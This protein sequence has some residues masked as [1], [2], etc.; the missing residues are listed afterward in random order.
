MAERFPLI[1]NS[2]ANQIQE[3]ASGD[4]LNLTGNNVHNAG[5]ITATTFKG[6]LTG[7]L[8]GNVTGNLTGTATELATNATGANL[9][10]SGNLG[11][12]GTLTYEDV[13]RVDAVGLSTFREGLQVGPLAGIAATVY[14]DGS[15]RSTGVVT[16]TTYY[17]DGSNLSGIDATAL[18]S[19]GAVKVQAN[20]HG[21]VTTGVMT[22]TS[23]K[24]DGSALTGIGGTSNII[25]DFITVQGNTGVVTAAQFVPTLVCPQNRNLV[26]NG[27]M[28]VWQRESGIVNSETSGY[29]GVDRYY[30]QMAGT[31]R[32]NVY[33]DSSRPSGYVKSMKVDVSTANASPGASHHVVL[34]HRIEG[35][36]LQMLQAGLSSAVPMTLSFWVKSPKT[37]THIAELYRQT[38]SP[39][40]SISA[41]YTVSSA[42]TWEYKTITFPGDTSGS[43]IPNS[44][45]FDFYIGIWLM[46]GSNFT[47]GS[48]STSWANVSNST[49]A[50]GQVNVFDN[51]SNDF[52]L[53]GLQLEVG[54]VATP[55]EHQTYAETL[56]VCQRYY[57]RYGYPKSFTIDNGGWVDATCWAMMLPYDSDDNSGGFPFAT[58]M[59]ATPSLTGTDSQGGGDYIRIHGP[60]NDFNG[61]NY[62]QV[63]NSCTTHAGFHIDTPGGLS[64]TQ[65][66]GFFFNST[67]GWFAFSAEL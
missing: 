35:Q 4:S 52:Y 46:A 42:N 1:A 55:F 54:N 61:G 37:G 60:A 67:N 41:A 51:T 47:S 26:Q 31:Q 56:R 5:I 25:A 58:E 8:T 12:A 22:A 17:G 6:P 11:V 21:A 53:T 18:K 49:R 40:R 24:G 65:Q 27:G 34:Q 50:Q 59:R 23:F 13:T 57:Q 36:N 64:T 14:K 43:V 63:N 9:T 3:I 2:S 16:A 28:T 44:N 15:I 62:F 32:W 45:A 19:G 33:Q 10:L 48:L 7:N 38:A 20:S 30:W 39:N 66:A 29:Y